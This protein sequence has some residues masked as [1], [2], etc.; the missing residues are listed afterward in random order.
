MRF[1]N[2]HDLVK[3]GRLRKARCPLCLDPVVLSA[4][5][6]QLPPWL[7]TYAWRSFAAFLASTVLPR[8]V[9]SFRMRAFRGS[10][11]ETAT[12][13]SALRFQLM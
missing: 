11:S 2:L 13:T 8:S 10:L 4:C 6:P 7:I 3:D 1:K 12:F 9:A 5:H